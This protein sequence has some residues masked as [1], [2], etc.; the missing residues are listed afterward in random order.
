MPGSLAPRQAFAASLHADRIPVRVRNHRSRTGADPSRR[1]CPPSSALRST[2]ARTPP[3][4]R[5][6]SACMP[7]VPAAPMMP[8]MPATTLS[9]YRNRTCYQ[10]GDTRSSMWTLALCALQFAFLAVVRRGDGS[11]TP[12]RCSPN[13]TRRSPPS[14]GCWASAAPR[15]TSTCPNSSPRAL[16]PSRPPQHAPNSK[17]APNRDQ[18]P[19]SPRIDLGIL[20]PT[21]R[22]C[23]I[24]A[25]PG[26][27]LPV[28]E[29]DLD[30]EQAFLKAYAKPR[31]SS[32]APQVRRLRQGCFA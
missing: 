1:P 22:F 32:G 24:P 4:A 16:R 12:A 18:R 15:S 23:R 19:L 30:F 2:H 29:Q 20:T 8:T 6:I 21:A 10:D 13:R 27:L 11:G 3:C 9:D 25:A 28:A 5:A 31:L 26:Q 7:P 17:Q 14:P